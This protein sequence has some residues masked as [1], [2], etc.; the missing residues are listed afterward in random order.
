MIHAFLLSS[1]FSSFTE[2][3][4]YPVVLI[5]CCSLSVSTELSDRITVI[6]EDLD[7]DTFF[8]GNAERIALL[9]CASHMPHTIPEI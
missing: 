6:P 7:E 3:I 5:T 1:I 2:S 9:I 4:T 8:T